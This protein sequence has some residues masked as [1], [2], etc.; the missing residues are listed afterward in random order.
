M[1]QYIAWSGMPLALQREWQVPI[2]DYL[3]SL[4][5][6][7][8]PRKVTNRLHYLRCKLRVR[9]VPYNTPCV[10]ATWFGICMEDGAWGVWFI[11]PSGTEWNRAVT[12]LLTQ[13]TT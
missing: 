6:R 1:S 10:A 5:L 3:L 11:P 9:G 7:K 8:A 13:L 4:R 2:R 12:L